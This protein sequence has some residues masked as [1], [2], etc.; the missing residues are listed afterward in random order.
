MPT[1]KNEEIA[2]FNPEQPAPVVAAL[3]AILEERI[4]TDTALK[5]RRIN[6]AIRDQLSDVAA[7]FE[8]IREQHAARDEETGELKKADDGKGIVLADPE[9]FNAAVN[10]LLDATFEVAEFLTPRD[11]VRRVRDETGKV[12]EVDDYPGEVIVQ[13]GELLQDE[14][15][16]AG[17]G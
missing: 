14:P 3:R 8:R 7:E 6:R 12:Y 10:A 5:I 9:G 15:A 17:G 1:L 2:S 4:S 13:L 11:L 16:P